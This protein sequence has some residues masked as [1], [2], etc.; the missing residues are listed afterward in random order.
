MIRTLLALWAA[1]FVAAAAATP[2]KATPYG[3][4]Y[5][6]APYYPAPIARP[7]YYTP[8][9]AWASEPLYHGPTATFPPGCFRARVYAVGAWRPV[10]IC[11]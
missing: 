11:Y 3:W 6:A 9:P 7:G 4:A 5:G 8:P 1:I 2:A 10:R